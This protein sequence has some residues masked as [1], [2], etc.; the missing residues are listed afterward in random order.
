MSSDNFI[1]ITNSQNSDGGET[2]DPHQESKADSTK[3]MSDSGVV[4]EKILEETIT[5]NESDETMSKESIDLFDQELFDRG[6]VE[7]IQKGID[8]EFEI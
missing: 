1:L 4:L 2:T 6:G 5:L 8:K 7:I 3:I